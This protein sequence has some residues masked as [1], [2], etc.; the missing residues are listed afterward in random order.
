M[1]F[2]SFTTYPRPNDQYKHKSS[3][4]I[5]MVRSNIFRDR[6][7]DVSF[8]LSSWVN[9]FIVGVLMGLIAFIIDVLVELL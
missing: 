2:K 5:Q 3:L 8:R 4:D 6:H 1:E 9:F 7:N